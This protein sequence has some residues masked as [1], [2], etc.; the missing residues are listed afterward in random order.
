MQ[1]VAKLLLGLICLTSLLF[2][3]A[4]PANAHKPSDSYVTLDWDAQGATGHWDIALRDLD[5]AVGLDAD[6]DGA[7]T[8]G[9]VRRRKDRIEA[10]A[11]S[12]LRLSRNGAECT[13]SPGQ[14]LIDRH[15]DGSYA[16]LRFSASCPAESGPIVVGYS[17]FFALDPTHHGLLHLRADGRDVSTVFTPAAPEFRADAASM[18]RWNDF[19]HYVREGLWHIWVGY[20]HLAFLVVLLLPV[21]L[22]RRAGVWEP[23]PDL[24]STAIAVLKIVTAFTVAHSITLSL[25]VLGIVTLPA[26]PVEIAIAVS[27]AVAAISNLLPRQNHGGTSWRLGFGFG[28]LHGFGFANVLKDLGLNGA[29][30]LATLAGFNVGVE[31]GQ[32]A[33]VAV[34]LPVIYA[35]RTR[36]FY[37]Y[38][39]LPGGSIALACLAG[40]WI[41]QRTVGL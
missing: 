21:V 6:G 37:R 11:F 35:V 31:L 13:T 28:L 15:S 38:V 24:S 22:R 26:R 32:L 2:F 5:Y 4:L 1:G 8:W 9:E 3:V 10:Y 23:M 40:V 7:I 18:T 12:H 19:A 36:A 16:V 34:L 39:I 30:L 20:D 17:L 33:L 25:A 29:G 14:Q 27:V 41:W